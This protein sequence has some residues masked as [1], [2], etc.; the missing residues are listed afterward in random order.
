MG[1]LTGRDPFGHLRV[2]RRRTDPDLGPGR[3]QRG[4]LASGHNTAADHQ[5][6]PVA[7]VEKRG[8][9]GWKRGLDGVGHGLPSL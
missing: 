6:R 2:Q 5:H 3:Q 7:E 4:D 9:Q 8:E 1:D